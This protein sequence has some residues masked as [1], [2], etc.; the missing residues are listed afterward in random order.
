MFSTTVATTLV[1]RIIRDPF[2]HALAG[3]LSV[4]LIYLVI[5]EIVRHNARLSRMKGPRGLPLVGN[6]P[7]IQQDAAETYRQWAKKYGDVYQ[8]MLGN[9]PVVV[10]NSAEAV[11]SI[12]ASNGQTLSSR[13]EFYTFHKVRGL[14]SLVDVVSAERRILTGL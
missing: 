7:D 1:E 4:P 12:F 3:A 11:K 14:L 9:L 5:N 8:I 6:I 10:I 2:R 13:P